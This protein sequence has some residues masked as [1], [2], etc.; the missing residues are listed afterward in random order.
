M[1]VIVEC[2]FI[3]GK[4]LGIIVGEGGLWNFVFWLWYGYVIY[5]IFLVRVIC[6]GFVLYRVN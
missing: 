1:K 2:L 3:S 4:N 6:I 5:E